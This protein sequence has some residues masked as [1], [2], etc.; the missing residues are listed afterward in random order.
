LNIR[1]PMKKTRLAALLLA[2]FASHQAMALDTYVGDPGKLGDPASWRTPEFTRDWGLLAIGAEYAYA[3]G[4]AGG[5]VKIGMVDSGYFAAHPDLPSARYHPVSS[6]GIAGAYNQAYNDTHGTHVTGTVGASRDGGAAVANMQGVAF[7]A[8]LYIGNDGKTDSVNYGTRIPGDSVALTLD[9][10]HVA[11]TYRAVNAQGVRMIGTSWGSQPINEQYQT[12]LPSANVPGFTLAGRVGL[13]GAWANLSAPDMWYQGAVDAARTGTI[14]LFSAGNGGYANASARAAATYFDPT[15]E[16]HWLAVAAISK[17]GQTFNADGSINV[18]GTQLYNQCGVSKWACVTAPGNAI[19]STTVTV[20][21]GVPTATYGSLS[22]TSMAQPHATGALALIMDRFSYM[23]NEQ[24]LS[25]MET[26]AVQNATINGT[27]LAASGFPA[28]IANPTA[29]QIVVVPD[30]RNGW[31]TVSVKNAMNGPGQFTGRFDVNTQGANDVWS[32][33]ISDTA[34]KARQV[35]DAAEAVS[36]TATKVAKG[37]TTGLPAGAS[38]EDQTSYQVGMARELAR[39]TRVYEGSLGKFGAGALVLSG[40][41]SFSGGTSLHGGALIAA[42]ATAF[43]SGDVDV[44]GGTLATRSASTVKIGGDLTLGSGGELDLGLGLGSG[45]LLSV[46]GLAIFDG[47]LTVSFLDGF[48]FAGSHLYE[49]IDF[50]SSEGLFSAYAFD[51]LMDGYT[52]NVIYTA[53]GVELNLVAVPVPE[54]ETYALMLGGLGLMAW[55]A[56]HRKRA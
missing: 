41:N 22:G 7:N 39:S 48:T 52:A 44:F 24:A 35:E 25:V 8:N 15:L 20:T 45:A 49:L 2:S 11:N 18:P 40:N 3:L 38:A 27:V 5:S 47:L 10:A 30:D 32:N 9:Q 1:P 23:T 4:F 29:G 12:L 51:G 31:G 21:G 17:T 42:S 6:D 54:P 28:P 34:I 26:T 33:N 55:M 43:G 36:W 50:G 14:M 19:N 46:H 37:W 16:G 56:R 13:Q 53:N